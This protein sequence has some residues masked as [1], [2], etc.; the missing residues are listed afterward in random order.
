MYVMKANTEDDTAIY[1]ANYDGDRIT[2][3]L[4]QHQAQRFARE[5][6]PVRT[7]FRPVKLVPKRTTPIDPALLADDLDG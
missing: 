5:D 2:F 7:G 3:T 1:I 6:C 4:T